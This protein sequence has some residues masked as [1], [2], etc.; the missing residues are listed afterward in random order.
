[1]RLILDCTD[2][3]RGKKN[4]KSHGATVGFAICQLSSIISSLSKASSEEL[5]PNFIKLIPLGVVQT[6][7]KYENHD[8]CCIEYMV[9]TFKSQVIVG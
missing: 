7:H 9:S 8:I 2:K 6:G 5:D 1:M 4:L 3:I